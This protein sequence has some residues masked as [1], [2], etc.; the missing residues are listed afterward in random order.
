MTVLAADHL[1]DLHP[2]FVGATTSPQKTKLLPH[3]EPVVVADRARGYGVIAFA[4]E[5]ATT[6]LVA[7]TTRHTS[8][9][10]QVLLPPDTCDKLDLGTVGT[11]GTGEG[12]RHAVTVDAAHGIST[13][14]SATDRARTLQLLLDPRSIAEDFTRPGHMVPINA[15][16]VADG[17]GAYVAAMMTRG[18]LIGAAFAE[19]VSTQAPTE[20]AGLDEL[21]QFCTEHHLRLVEAEP[22]VIEPVAV[23]YLPLPSGRF[24]AVA[25]PDAA[26][27][28]EHFA[29]RS[30]GA[31]S[32]QHAGVPVY[33]HLE[34]PLGDVFGSVACECAADL[35]AAVR[36]A[37]T[38]P[39]AVI[40]YLR[41][42]TAGIGRGECRHR[43]LPQTATDA[44]HALL[45]TLGVDRAV[46][47]GSN[48]PDCGDAARIIASLSAA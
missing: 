28:V 36:R 31:N 10:L 11:V 6:E 43:R 15:D 44:A 45:L 23:T 13:G 33:I 17:P 21:A 9:F 19:V 3:D 34:C 14:I 26:R 30:L 7:F 25:V 48:L 4:A 38:H 1:A 8:G 18:G 22:P 2:P 20:L 40:V 39:G 16:S 37:A 5:L 32:P 24:T 42:D 46:F 41:A 29:L 47:A 12:Y 27:S 35:E